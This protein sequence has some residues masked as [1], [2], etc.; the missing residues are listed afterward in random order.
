[1]CL[2]FPSFS[3]GKGSSGGEK[4]CGVVDRRVHKPTTCVFF[5]GSRSVG[6]TTSFLWV[7]QPQ[8]FSPSV[9]LY[10]VWAS[11]RPRSTSTTGSVW[12]LWVVRRMRCC[13]F[14]YFCSRFFL[15]G[16]CILDVVLTLLLGNM[17]PFRC[18][19]RT[20]DTPTNKQQAG[21]YRACLPPL[22]HAK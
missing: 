19:H 22:F 13:C 9:L 4:Y 21:T 11:R 5:T 15:V 3:W 1:M 16:H 8:Q 2:P 20:Q 6:G 12:S 7:K 10:S 17:E 14:C 18:S